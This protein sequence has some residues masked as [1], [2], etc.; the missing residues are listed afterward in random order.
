MEGE[1]I[2]RS[3]HRPGDGTNGNGKPRAWD[4]CVRPVELDIYRFY[5]FPHYWPVLREADNPYLDKDEDGW[6]WVLEYDDPNKKSKSWH[7]RDYGS[8]REAF[9]RAKEAYAEQFDDGKHVLVYSTTTEIKMEH[10][11]FRGR[12]EGD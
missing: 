7:G 6:I 1:R 9:E 2:G 12:R 10:F 4:S 11:E 8:F 3:S 5:G